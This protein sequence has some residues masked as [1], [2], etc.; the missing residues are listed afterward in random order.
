M[1]TIFKGTPVYDGLRSDCARV[2]SIE[3]RVLIR[4]V[5]RVA[6]EAITI[7]MTPDQARDLAAGIIAAAEKAEKHMTDPTHTARACPRCRGTGI[8]QFAPY[9]IGLRGGDLH[10]M[11]ACDCPAG[12]ALLSGKETTNE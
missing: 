10:T 1:T 6:E 4:A 5:D 9:M 7:A 12:K 3:D 11:A 2:T 8:A